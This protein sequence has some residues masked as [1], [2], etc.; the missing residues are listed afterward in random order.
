MAADV[1][2]VEKIAQAH[3]FKTFFLFLWNAFP[4]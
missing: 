2:D 4:D 1:V 3:A